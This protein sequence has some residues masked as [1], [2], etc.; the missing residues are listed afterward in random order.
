M[1][2][3]WAERW[4]A[5]GDPT[6]LHILRLLSVRDACVCELVEL[7]PI[8]QSAVSQH[9]RKL[10]YAGFVR[11]YRE[12][13]WIF[14]ALRADMPPA[15]TSVLQELSIPEDEVTWLRSHQVGASCAIPGVV[16]VEDVVG[17]SE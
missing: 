14:Y 15:V 13:S 5:L 10:K 11:D 1:Y 2:E 17:A 3:E 4:R 6:R 8:S 7:L 16:A 9:L 12:K